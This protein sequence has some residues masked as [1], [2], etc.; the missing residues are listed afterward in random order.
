M[1]EN[2]GSLGCLS[3]EVSSSFA[4]LIVVAA[5]DMWTRRRAAGDLSEF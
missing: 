2:G 5:R 1:Q 3:L 4:Q